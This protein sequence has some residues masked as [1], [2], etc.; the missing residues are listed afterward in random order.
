[1]LWSIRERMRPA[2][3]VIDMIPDIHRTPALAALRKAVLDGRA[4]R[5]RLDRDDRDLAFYDGTVA[6]VSPIGARL[7]LGLYRDGRLKLKK[8]AKASLPTL[9]AYV[10]TEAAFREQVAAILAEAEAQAARLA[11]II[12]DP[13][14][15]TA[16]ELST[17]L[18]DK[19]MTAHLGRGVYGSMMIAGLACH[20]ALL[21][22]PESE[23]ARTRSEGK[24]VIWWFDAAGKRQGDSD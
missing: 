16:E 8:P 5:E 24:D 6:L 19:V 2:L 10:A 17:S 13:A 23:D 1:M 4:G 12:A 20:K 9:E 14:A 11:A 7:L 22:P 15:A 21:L 3:S 18:I